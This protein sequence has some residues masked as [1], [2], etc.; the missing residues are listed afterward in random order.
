M[1]RLK[2]IIEEIKCELKILCP[3]LIEDARVFMTD[4]K[5]DHISVIVD[6]HHKIYPSGSEYK[7]MRQDVLI[8][9]A[10]VMERNKVQFALPSIVNI[11][12]S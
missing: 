8:A 6:T 10:N 1:H 7:L 12:N 3:K 5:K 2:K 11:D 4:Y 9:I